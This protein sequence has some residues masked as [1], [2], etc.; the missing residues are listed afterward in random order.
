MSRQ[1]ARGRWGSVVGTATPAGETPVVISAGARTAGYDPPEIDRV[2]VGGRVEHTR[3]LA[4]YDVDLTPRNADA[5]VGPVTVGGDWV[6]SSLV[7][8]VVDGGDGFGNGTDAVMSGPAVSNEQGPS[9]IGRIVIRGDV[10]G[11]P[12]GVSAAD[13]YGFVAQLIDGLRVGGRDYRLAANMA[14]ARDVGPTGD[15]R[16]LELL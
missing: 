13:H 11:T 6:A 1:R 12:A 5:V 8:G 3:I 4:G 16:L 15:V 10:V 7:A 14:D 2:T 9:R